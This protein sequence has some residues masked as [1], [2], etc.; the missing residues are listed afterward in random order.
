[1]AITMPGRGM[2]LLRPN[3]NDIAAA[4][5]YPAKSLPLV[6]RLHDEGNH[7]HVHMMAWSTVPSEA[8]LTR[9]GIRNIKSTLTNQI[10][11]QELLHTYEQK[12]QSR[13]EL[14]WEAR[15]AIRKLTR[16]MARSMHGFLLLCHTVPAGA[17]ASRTAPLKAKI[18]LQARQLSCYFSDNRRLT[19]WLLGPH[20]DMVCR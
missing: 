6:R 7:P 19:L 12:S 16:E 8:Y 2:N 13:D 4:M 20:R 15:K 1:M 5:K 17:P 10:F 9:E 14:V 11:R 18:R 3:R